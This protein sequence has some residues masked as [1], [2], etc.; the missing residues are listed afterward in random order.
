MGISGYFLY[1]NSGKKLHCGVAISFYDMKYVD[2]SAPMRY[3][4]SLI[5][6]EPPPIAD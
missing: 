4:F 6:D 1:N 3:S 5:P 2:K